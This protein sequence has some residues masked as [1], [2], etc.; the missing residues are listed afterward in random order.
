MTITPEAI[1]QAVQRALTAKSVT[2]DGTTV[3][4][5]AAS[6][7]IALSEWKNSQARQQSRR[8]PVRKF[9]VDLG[10]IGG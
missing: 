4:M 3:Q 8:L 5:P 1:D 10:G 6:D 7:V 9:R 2:V